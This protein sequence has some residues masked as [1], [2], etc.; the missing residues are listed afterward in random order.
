MKCQSK[1]EK[2]LLTVLNVQSDMLEDM[3]YAIHDATE[4]KEWHNVDEL[5]QIGDQIAFNVEMHIMLLNILF[6]KRH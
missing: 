2:Q 6:V 3:T 1:Y 5:R 4:R